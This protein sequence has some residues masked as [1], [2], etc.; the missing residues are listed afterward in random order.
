MA[1]SSAAE[2]RREFLLDP[3]IAFLNHGSF[4]ACPRPVFERYQARQ[5][6][7][8]LE[9]VDFL[10]RRLPGLLDD[11]RAVLAKYVGCASQ[12]L[13][14]V[15]NATTGV[16]LAARSL[17]LQRG[18]EISRP[19]SSTAPA[20]SHGTGS[21]RCDRTG[22]TLRPGAASHFPLRAPSELV[23]ALFAAAPRRALGSSNVRARAPGRR[24]R[25]HRQLGLRRR[26]ELLPA[27]RAAGNARSRGM[28]CRP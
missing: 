5:R 1:A 8:E 7:L 18:D 9:P 2:L 11:A 19:T 24:R 14:F 16:N 3:E 20:I 4:G 28:A 23:E 21:A 17:D 13:A 12:D 27:A 22:V 26:E 6:E 10:H 15:Q 25:R